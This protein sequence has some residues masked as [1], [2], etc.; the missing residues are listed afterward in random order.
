DDARRPRG[1]DGR[2]RRRGTALTAAPASADRVGGGRDADAVA[3][4]RGGLERSSAP[5]R[6]AAMVMRMTRIVAALLATLASFVLAAPAVAIDRFSPLDVTTL[7]H[8]QP[9][10]GSDGR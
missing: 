4:P 7:G 9:V 1:A 8:L 5:A 3:C 6:V 10:K 2:R